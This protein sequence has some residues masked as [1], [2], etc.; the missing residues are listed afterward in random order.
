MTLNRLNIVDTTDNESAFFLYCSFTSLFGLIS[1]LVER[2][3]DRDVL[4]K[5]PLSKWLMA[6]STFTSATHCPHFSCVSLIKVCVYFTLY[7]R[8]RLVSSMVRRHACYREE[9]GS[10]PTRW[11]LFLLVCENNRL[12][13]MRMQWSEVYIYMMGYTHISGHAVLSIILW[14]VTASLF[15]SILVLIFT[16]SDCDHYTMK[17]VHFICTSGEYHLIQREGTDRTDE[18]RK[19]SCEKG[20]KNFMHSFT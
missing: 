17:K 18:W 19:A 1:R 3:I 12:N 20:I 14:L 2:S 6:L 5:L 11:I 9:L 10:N 15:L 16:Q 13:K 4:K 8:L 7:V